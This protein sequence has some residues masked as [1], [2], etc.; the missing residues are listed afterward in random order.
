MSVPATGAPTAAVLATGHEKATGSSSSNTATANT[1][2]ANTATATANVV[3]AALEQNVKSSSGTVVIPAPRPA[4]ISAPAVALKYTGSYFYTYSSHGSRTYLPCITAYSL[5][6]IDLELAQIERLLKKSSF[7]KFSDHN[8]IQTVESLSNRKQQ[9]QELRGLL[10]EVIEAEQ[11]ENEYLSC[12]PLLVES[13]KV[14]AL[15]ARRNE[16][17][18]ILKANRIKS[19]TILPKIEALVAA[20]QKPFYVCLPK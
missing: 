15:M 2:T 5:K 3:L 7:T 14:H 16:L 11:I 19:M 8:F 9:F 13:D 17:R 1:A 6:D 20:L 12:Q 18:A 10:T 4:A